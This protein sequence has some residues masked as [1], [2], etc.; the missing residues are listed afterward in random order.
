M[1]IYNKELQKIC[2]VNIE[3][4]KNISLKYRMGERNG[5]GKEYYNDGKLEFEGN[6]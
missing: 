4:N 2:L 5:K 6:I 1:I 3:D